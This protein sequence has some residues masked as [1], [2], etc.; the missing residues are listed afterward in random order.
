MAQE[1]Q[2]ET[3]YKSPWLGVPPS[4]PPRGVEKF[5]VTFGDIPSGIAEIMNDSILSCQVNYS[6][7]MVTEITLNIS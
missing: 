3:S 1:T 6:M 4:M 5:Q 2:A 7:D